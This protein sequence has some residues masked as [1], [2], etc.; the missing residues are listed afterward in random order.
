MATIG[1]DTPK[2]KRTR[3]PR[4]PAGTSVGLWIARQHY[5][6]LP[7]VPQDPAVAAAWRLRKSDGEVYDVHIDRH[8]CHCT[9]PDHV[10]RRE[11]RTAEPCKHA[12]A[13]IAWRLLPVLVAAEMAPAPAPGRVELPDGRA[14]ETTAPDGSAWDQDPPVHFVPVEPEEP[15]PSA[16]PEPRPD[17]LD[18]ARPWYEAAPYT[19]ELDA[20]FYGLTDAGLDAEAD[21]LAA[22]ATAKARVESPFYL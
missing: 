10:Y 17:D 11:G 14:I 20:V 22:E 2:V 4:R 15:R 12:A 1:A 7:I 18:Q 16:R 13:L 9:C 8:G 5:R 3:K 19:D 21:C 6:L